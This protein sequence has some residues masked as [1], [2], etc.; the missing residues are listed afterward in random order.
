MIRTEAEIIPMSDQQGNG[1]QPPAD[2]R[3]LLDPLGADEL[4][5]LREARE[6]LRGNADSNTPKSAA[7]LSQQI[8]P[9]AAST[10]DDIGDA[11]TRAAMK[12]P[13]FDGA[14][15][16]PGFMAAPKPMS[17]ENARVTTSTDESAATV[18]SGQTP[19]EEDRAKAQAELNALQQN[20][21][22]TSAGGF[23]DN[24]LMWMSPVKPKAQEIIP[25]RGAAAAAGMIPTEVPKD[26]AGR[27][28]ATYL[29]GVVAVLALCAIGYVFFGTKAA[30]SPVEFVTNPGGATVSI[31]GKAMAVPTPMRAE[32]L[33]GVSEIEIKLDGYK[34][35]KFSLDVKNGADVVRKTFE[36]APLSKPG[37][38]TVSVEVSPVSAN[39]T[40]DQMEYPSRKIVRIANVDPNKPHKVTIVA[41]GYETMTKEIPAGQLQELY[42]FELKK[43]AAPQ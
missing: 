27:R 6:K 18:L 8:G 1:K 16:P 36:L 5:A 24:T 3:T 2:D 33:V 17:A 12:I 40:L 20:R 11:P 7:V 25:E 31:N 39:V 26:T 38:K 42:K 43:A 41:G 37:L 35:E 10:E 14:G 29:V 28:A 15:G 19:S 22:S 32:M 9:D 34:T 21:P 13:S 23:G 4:K 30:K